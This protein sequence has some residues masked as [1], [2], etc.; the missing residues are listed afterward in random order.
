MRVGLDEKANHF[1]LLFFSS[2]LR[3]LCT[4]RRGNSVFYFIFFLRLLYIYASV[5]PLSAS[6]WDVSM[7][8]R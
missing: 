5:S 8:L 1:D 4:H 6:I 7:C 2:F 3:L